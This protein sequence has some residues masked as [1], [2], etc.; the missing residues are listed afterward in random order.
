VPGVPKVWHKLF[1]KIFGFK[2][3]KA[4]FVLI[5]QGVFAR[6]FILNKSRVRD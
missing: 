1:F 6:E 2:F 3:S 4:V 5:L